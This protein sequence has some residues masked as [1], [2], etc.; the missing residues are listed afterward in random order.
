MIRL[1]GA[2]AYFIL[3][4]AFIVFAALFSSPKHKGHH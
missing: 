4:G 3:F 1:V 2:V